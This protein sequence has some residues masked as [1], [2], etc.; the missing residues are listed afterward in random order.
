METIK[1]FNDWS[2]SELDV[3]YSNAY[4]IGYRTGIE[5]A[6]HFANQVFEKRESES[7]TDAEKKLLSKFR[8][9]ISVCDDIEYSESQAAYHANVTAK[10]ALIEYELD[11]IKNKEKK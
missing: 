11:K 3:K 6:T 4:D 10:N 1:Y 5:M 8:R 9:I 7:Q 2:K